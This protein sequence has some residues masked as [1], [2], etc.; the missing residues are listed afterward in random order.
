MGLGERVLV[1]AFGSAP[2][3]P[4]WGSLLRRIA[5]AADDPAHA[6]FDVLYVV[7]AERSWYSGAPHSLQCRHRAGSLV[8]CFAWPSDSGLCA[9][10]LLR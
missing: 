9:L 7:D 3:V 8:R 5:K 10:L 1:V 2:G 6:F 4:N